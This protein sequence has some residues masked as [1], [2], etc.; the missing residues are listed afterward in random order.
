MNRVQPLS[1]A[2]FIEIK[3]KI[4]ILTIIYN[5]TKSNRSLLTKSIM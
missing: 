5:D 2:Y 3:N 1:I 4:E